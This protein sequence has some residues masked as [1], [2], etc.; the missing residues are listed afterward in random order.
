MK[1]K[2]YIILYLYLLNFALNQGEDNE[3]PIFESA[4]CLPYAIHKKKQGNH[5]VSCR[6]E[7]WSVHTDIYPKPIRQ[8]YIKTY[9][10]TACFS[11]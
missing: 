7:R 3:T 11:N 1:C 6:A 4:R 2:L 10:K 8:R 5:R 9:V